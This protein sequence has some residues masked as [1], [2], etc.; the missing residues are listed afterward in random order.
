MTCSTNRPIRLAAWINIH[1]QAVARAVSD[2]AKRDAV[3]I[4]TRTQHAVVGQLDTPEW[5]AAD[6]RFLQQRRRRNRARQANGIQALDR[7]RQVIALCGDGGFNMLMSEFLTAVHHKLP[8]KVIIY[9]NSA[10]GLIPLEAEAVGLPAYRDANE[11][12]QSGLQCACQSVR[13][14]WI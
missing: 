12:P 11:T 9:N 2:L 7:A 6:H 14:S 8:V 3:F 13:R 4:L 5:I 1:P 10:F